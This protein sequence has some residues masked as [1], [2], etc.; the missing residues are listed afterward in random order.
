M[1]DV[2][3]HVN[4]NKV[5]DR[6]S[7][8]SHVLKPFWELPKNV[9]QRAERLEERITKFRS[10]FYD[11]LRNQASGLISW[12]QLAQDPPLSSSSSMETDGKADYNTISSETYSDA[13]D[14]E[15]VNELPETQH[16]DKTFAGVFSTQLKDKAA[17]SARK[18][19]KN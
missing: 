14:G 9:K 7:L 15:G 18:S 8:W 17:Q 4:W 6:R 3:P 13:D 16:A 10:N 19:Q 11:L 5:V 12:R 1:A 2:N